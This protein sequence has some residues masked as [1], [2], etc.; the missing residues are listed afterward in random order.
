V[1]FK[2]PALMMSA[3]GAAQV[4]SMLA[5]SGVSKVLREY[6]NMPG[7]MH[8]RAS[9]I[10][11]ATIKSMVRAGQIEYFEPDY[12]LS[13]ND[14]GKIGITA[15]PNDSLYGA[16]WGLHNNG[17]NGTTADMDI[18]APE[19]WNI[20]SGSSTV[21]VGVVDTGIDYTHPDLSANMYVNSGEVSGNNIDDDGNGYTDD[22]YGYNCVAN[23][24]NPYDDHYHGTHVAGTI[25]AKGNNSTGVTGVNWNVKLMAL[26]FLNASGAGFTSDAIQCLDYA[27]TMKNRGVNLRVLNNSWGG[28]APSQS[29]IEAIERTNTAGMLFVAAAGN[30]ALNNDLGANGPGDAN[31]AN[32]ISVAALSSSGAL[33]GFS[34]YGATT[35]DIGAPGVG[36][37]STVPGNSYGYLN[38]TSMAA[39]H[40][41][42]VAALMFAQNG[43]LTPI[44]VKS[45]LMNS[46]MPLSNLNGYMV[47]PGMVNAQNAL[48]QGLSGGS[49]NPGNEDAPN[50]PGGDSDGDGVTD[51]Q[52][53]SD[54]TDSADAGSYRVTLQS[55]VYAQWTGFLDIV[56]I[57]ELVNPGDD[58]ITARIDMYSS[59]GTLIDQTFAVIDGKDQTDVMIS[60]LAGFTRNT[61]G[62]IKITYC[63]GA[64]EGRMSYYRATSG[65][66]NFDFAYHLPLSNPQ[67]GNSNVSFNSNQPSLNPAELANLVT[68]WL[69]LVNLSSSSKTFT[70]RRYNVNGSQLDSSTITLAAKQRVDIEGGHELPGPG[71][72]GLHSIT[73]NDSTAPY[74][75][76]L[77]RYGLDAAPGQVA[78]N[79][80]FAFPLLAKAGNGETMVVP[81]TT[82]VNA[83]NWLELVN[84]RNDSTSVT[85]N[86]Y[87]N[88][89]TLMATETA[90]LAAKA[91]V[92]YE[93]NSRLGNDSIGFAKI[94]P[95]EANSIISQSMVYVRNS[96]TGSINAMY[97][98]QAREA[99]TN[100]IYGTYNL[101]LNMYN[102]LKL[103][104]PTGTALSVLVTVYTPSNG[105]H[106]N[107]IVIPANGSSDLGIHEAES[108]GTAPNTYGVLQ[109]DIPGGR[110]LF[111]ELLRLRFNTSDGA[112][113]FI[114][115]SE[116]R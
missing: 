108:F 77:T 43:T 66:S 32:V 68:N 57:L 72:V 58:Q 10:N 90:N 109:I 84:T 54:G 14:D 4:N 52:E 29:L 15:T 2:N 28:V 42:G 95:T 96:A 45:R 76:F 55:P 82:T 79:T 70:I 38:G 61:Y 31:V 24:G 27:V 36:I 110:T 6:R 56:N 50:L 53:A 115:P 40:V 87:R 3:K 62:L 9:K 73:P 18:D 113:D 49:C 25:G 59:T 111:S 112:V 44:V 63:G 80:N 39:P 100:S 8:V 51:A 20:T 78:S 12:C 5:A 107:T 89:G 67:Y 30:S 47:A 22:V 7:L 103:I 16:M 19:A 60:S 114:A 97:G 98:S 37:L 48:T 34:N 104:N 92:H 116:V 94:I 65:S 105:T 23:N 35:V 74:I 46:I 13:V 101:N 83:Q 106:A 69:S 11:V 64:L 17:S 88:N 99:L 71:Y 93:V 85:V 102:W 33:A 81:L 41:A 91:Q 86:F 1:K 26:K 75:A 21:V